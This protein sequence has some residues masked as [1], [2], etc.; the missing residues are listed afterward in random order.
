ME[1]FPPLPDWVQV[2]H[3]VATLL[4]EQENHGWYFDERA[5]Q[6]LASS[7]QEELE[8]TKEDLR[9]RH[10]FVKGEEKTPKRN[11]KTQG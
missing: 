5:A 9:R 10:P 6:Q 8:K 3:Q 7:L 1:A 2:E 11:N 4:T